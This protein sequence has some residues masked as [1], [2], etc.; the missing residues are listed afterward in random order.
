MNCLCA[1]CLLA[2]FSFKR[3]S[4]TDGNHLYQIG[5]LDLWF[6]FERRIGSGP[7]STSG[8]FLAWSWLFGIG[9]YGSGWLLFKLRHTP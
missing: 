5:F 3:T 6:V 7:R 9:A 4:D 2:F 1:F 8:I